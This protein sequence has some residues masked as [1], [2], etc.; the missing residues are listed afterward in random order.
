MVVSFLAFKGISILFPDSSVDKESPCNVEDLGLIPGLGRS[1]GEGKGYPLQYSGL[2]NS[3]G[4]L[5]H[6]VTELDT[7]EQLSLSLSILF[8]MVAVSCWIPTN[9]ARRVL[10]SPHSLQHLLFVDLFVDGHS[11]WCDV[12][13]HCSFDLHFSNMEQCWASF[14]VFISHL[15]VF[16]GEMSVLFSAHFLIGLFVFL[17]TAIFKLVFFPP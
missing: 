3:M 6:G 12:I 2:E 4:C 16:F 15:Y 17:P 8:S 5:D 9:S 1:P 13:P 14:C 11:D 10:F 7:T